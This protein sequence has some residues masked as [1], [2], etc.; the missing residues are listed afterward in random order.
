M[1][2]WPYRWAIQWRNNNN[3]EGYREHLMWDWRNPDR[4]SPIMFRTRKEARAYINEHYSYIRARPDLKAEP[5]GWK[6]PR[7]CKVKVSMEE[8]SDE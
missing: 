2:E 6:C 3:L 5:F 8:P 4:V 7:V 1:A